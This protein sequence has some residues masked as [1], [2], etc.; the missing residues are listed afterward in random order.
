MSEIS[1]NNQ[2]KNK[3]LKSSQDW[4]SIFN[5]FT[6]M[7]TIH[8][9]DFNILSANNAAKNILGLPSLDGT[10]IKCFT[11]YHGSD[12]VPD[13][14]PS[15]KCI[16]TGK[17]A[18]FEMFEPHL[19]RFIEIRAIPRFN[20]NKLI[21]LTHIV[22]DITDRK[23]TNDRIKQI[24][25]ELQ[26]I[27]DAIRDHITVQ[28]ANYRI[29]SYNKAVEKHFGKDLQGKLCYEVY[30]SRKEICPDCA[31]KKVI[32]TK[33]PA[34]TFQ[35]PGLSPPIEIYA[36]PIF[37]ENG[38]VTAIVEHGR[39]VSEKLQILKALQESEE[40]YR[41]LITNIPVV[42]WTTDYNGNT[43]FISSNVEKMYGYTPQEVCR[44]KDSLWFG[45]IHPDDVNNVKRA[46][47]EIFEKDIPLD[48]EYRIQRKDGEWIWLLDRSTCTYE[49]DGIKYA[50]GVFSDITKRKK[51][52]EELSHHRE[53]LSLLVKEQTSELTSVI[54][55]LRDEITDRLDIE[56]ALRESEKR[57]RELFNFM[58]SGVAVYSAIDNGNDFIFKDFNKAGEQIDNIKKEKL[59]GKRVTEA[60]PGVKEFGLFDVFQRVWKTGKSEQH[61]ISHYKDNR[62]DG[63]RENYV[64]KLPSG[65]IVAVYD[66]IT[67]H[68]QMAERETKLLS[69]LRNIFRNIPLAIIYLDREYK[70]INANKF[71]YDITGLKKEDVIGKPCYDTIGEFADDP[72][73]K[74]LEKLCT[75]CKK[76]ECLVTKKPTVIE[77]PLKDKFLRVTTIPELD[78]N[79]DIANFLEIGE[80]ITKH[81]FSEAEAIRASHLAALGELSAGV[82]HE[83]NNP[84]SGIINYAQILVNKI[85]KETKEHDIARRILRESDRIA[86][87]VMSLLSFARDNKD[88]RQQ[89]Y[90]R[91]IIFDSLSL[92]KTQINNDGIRLELDV[93]FN[94]PQIFV[95]PQQIEQVILNIISNARYALNKK[96]P[97]PHKDKI[98]E[99]SA[100]EEIIENNPYIQIKFH[101]KGIGIPDRI[102]EKIMNPFFSTKPSGS[103]TGLGLSISHGIIVNHGGKLLID[104]IEGKF[105]NVVINL[106]VKK[107]KGFHLPK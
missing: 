82:A 18:V 90:I 11:Y 79:G 76:P 105:T 97:K 93:P 7:I 63:W 98:L 83:I 48:I 3:A 70:I 91:E 22:R 62:I 13:G 77:R 64:Y 52:E 5:S 60:F 50:D 2:I 49:K 26:S 17:P 67:E 75:F 92:T 16:K 44:G 53:K 34:F 104:S 29:L 95:Q 41:S 65:E 96:Y 37:D 61:P 6:D 45:R 27:Y 86:N 69:E 47:K 94:L 24:K 15:C 12:S 88:K 87:I 81:K 54:E 73:K 38:E 20:D 103:S 99:I 57:Y 40:K 39:D 89:V 31:V 21:G 35:N 74:G 19:N 4:E 25:V 10:K 80:D 72:T 56:K 55:L 30:Q 23:E 28:G 14:C 68:M 1:H 71:F 100:K 51:M 32:E 85:D 66:D 9:R 102:L 33:K 42:S 46:F 106:P 59:I 107:D 78:E 101:D 84:I 43:I 58:S 8:D 36:Y